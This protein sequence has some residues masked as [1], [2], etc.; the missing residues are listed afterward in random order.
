MIK[1]LLVVILFIINISIIGYGQSTSQSTRRIWS[2]TSLPSV[3]QPTGTNIFYKSDTGVLY[4]C[5]ATNTWTAIGSPAGAVTT[6]GGT[7]NTIA[8]FTSSTV[9]GN[10]SVT[11]DGT[12]VS[13]GANVIP[14]TDNAKTLGS[15]SKQWSNIWTAGQIKFNGAS[16]D[17]IG[18]TTSVGPKFLDGNVGFMLGFNLQSLTTDRV[19]IWPNANSSLPVYAQTIT[20]TGL[21]APRTVT[22]P[23]SNFTA[24]RTDAGQTFTGAQVFTS[25][26]SLLSGNYTIRAAAASVGTG[27]VVDGAGLVDAWLFE[28]TTGNLRLTNT[29]GQLAWGN[30]SA[31]TGLTRNAANNVGITNGSSTTYQTLG[32]S[33]LTFQNGAAQITG[34]AGNMT[35]TSGT[36]NSR[37]MQLQTTTSGGVA[38]TF[39]TGN[40]DQSATFAAGGSFVGTLTAGNFFATTGVIRA[41]IF[42]WPSTSRMTSTVDG[43]ITLYNNGQTDFSRLQLGG[44]TSSFPAIKRSSTT[45]AFRLADDSAD[46]PI[47]SAGITASGAITTSSTTDSTTTTSGALQVAGG[48]AIRKRVF[49]DGITTSSGLQTAVLCQSSGGEMIADS[50]ACLASSGR[51]KQN[52]KPLVSGLDEVMKLK[53]VSYYYK[54]EGIFAHNLNFQR[55][56]VGFI[57]EDIAKIDTR[58]VGYEADGIT[59]RTVSYEMIVPLLVK[60]IQELELKIERLEHNQ[61]KQH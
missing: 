60:S 16:G 12:N 4:S 8:K 35:I 20:Y 44:T 46:A 59:P 13:S 50:V 7:A 42:D 55:E 18:Y 47:S 41:A 56:R 30:T 14:T 61:Q 45:T 21:T 10:S 32:S 58:F 19:V 3:C 25:G 48:A 31:D 26:V 39:L 23:D 15:S 29:S 54:P 33:G 24:A 22:Y 52:I 34:G 53:P 17:A 11:D 5:T 9:I 37:T 43:I 49:I 1:R 38:T 27:V 57:A 6:A 51:F 2:G 40:A 28:D 36:G